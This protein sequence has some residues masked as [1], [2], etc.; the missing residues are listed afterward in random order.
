[1]IK[2]YDELTFDLKTLK[3]EIQDFCS[4]CTSARNMENN[5]ATTFA[6]SLNIEV[7]PNKIKSRSI[8][9][10]PSRIRTRDGEVG[11]DQII[12]ENA[13]ENA[14]SSGNSDNSN[15]GLPD[16]ITLLQEKM[17]LID[18]RVTEM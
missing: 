13:N 18:S 1:M 5:L 17:L 2:N 4:M 10:D 11:D 3:N 8:D 6:R 9:I 12:N 15:N 7:D 14:N 16:K